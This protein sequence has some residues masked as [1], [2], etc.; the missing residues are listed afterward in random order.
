MASRLSRSRSRHSGGAGGSL[1]AAHQEGCRGEGEPRPLACSWS[2]QGRG[3]APARA[4]GLV[5]P[6]RRARVRMAV[7][8]KP[9]DRASS[10]R[11]APPS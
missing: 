4:S 3:L 7:R 2:L 5:Q 8:D 6:S 9:E 10:L 1:H 11:L